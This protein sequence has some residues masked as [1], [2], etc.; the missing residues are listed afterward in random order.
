MTDD[1]QPNIDKNVTMDNQVQKE[2]ELTTTEEIKRGIF[3]NYMI[4]NHSPEDFTLDFILI[5][6]TGGTLNSRVIVTPSHFKRMITVMA[7]NL[8][9]YEEKYGEIP[10]RQ[11]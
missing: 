3:S 8:K 11:I 2:L 1:Q 9:K 7:D 4:V 6:R 10:E 5:S